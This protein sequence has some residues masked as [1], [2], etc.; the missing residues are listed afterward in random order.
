MLVRLDKAIDSVFQVA[1]TIRLEGGPGPIPQ[2]R[3]LGFHW[4]YS[5]YVAAPFFNH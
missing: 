1:I 3:H 2:T 5:S 4:V